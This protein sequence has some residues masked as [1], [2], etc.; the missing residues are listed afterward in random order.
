M[1][2]A[3]VGQKLEAERAAV[4]RSLN[5]TKF[6]LERLIESYSHISR[7][8][9]AAQLF[10][11]EAEFQTLAHMLR[12]NNPSIVNIARSQDFIITDVHPVEPNRDLLGYDYRANPKQMASVQRALDSQE[13]IIV[14]PMTLLQGGLGLLLRNAQPGPDNIVGNIVLD[15]N[16]ILTEAGM[17]AEPLV[18]ASSARIG[19]ADT[20]TRVVFGAEAVW[21]DAPVLANF[22]L[23]D[24]RL[25]LAKTPAG[26]W[27][28]DTAHRPVL[29]LTTAILVFIALFGVNY[30][31]RLIV[32]RAE[33]RRQLIEAIESIH[34]G[35]V[36]FDQQD[37]LV[38]C[39]QKYRDFFKASNNLIVP[40][41]SFEAILRDEVKQGQYPEAKGR[42]EDWIAKRLELHANPN[43]QSEIELA[44]GSWLKVSE[45]QTSN[46]STVGIRTD[47]T[48]LKKALQTAEEAVGAKTEFINNMN[49]E[50]R[51]PLS[52]ILG[53]I[54][55]LRKV[56]LYPQ[57]KALRN[58]L[59]TDSMLVHLL[60][61]FTGVVVNQAT[62]SEASGKH[63]LGL[64]N[65]VLDWAK[66]SSGN[67]ELNIETVKLDIL[68]NELRDEFGPAATEKGLRLEV[69]AEPVRI[70][71]DPLRLRQIFVNLLNNAIKFTDSGF[72]TISVVKN[73]TSTLVTVED[74]GHGIPDDQL[75]VIFD[76]FTQVGANQKGQAGTGLGLAITK[77][78]VQLH[79]GQI[80]VS[81]TYGKGSK[82]QVMFTCDAPSSGDMRIEVPEK[83]NTAEIGSQTV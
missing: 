7:S 20:G 81:S 66:L 29:I 46:G 44:D 48:E 51:A 58:K 79:G 47:I 75:N 68:L 9:A 61:E 54:A 26:G 43:A 18:F 2:Q 67:A 73:A 6:R 76:R 70:E 15:F 62:K 63:L 59:E 71:G 13:T 57:Y 50:L 60:D 45:S 21:S 14:G 39:N 52:V 34:D 28:T 64:I 5:L 38:L 33:A 19:D 82:F 53:Y 12:D 36:I 1:D 37:Q 10:E 23:G 3:I 25:E 16:R 80:S 31:R 77:N 4:Q 8:L 55:F 11:T 32:E 35:F 22:E 24:V 40:G 69:L 41:M 72:I 56:E 83:T 49:H 17:E 27:N 65:S 74:S 78:L 30:A 42:E